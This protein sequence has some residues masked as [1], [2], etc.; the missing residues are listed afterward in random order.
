MDILTLNNM[1][2]WYIDIQKAFKS[3]EHNFCHAFSIVSALLELEE[4][5]KFDYFILKLN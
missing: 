4:H 1:G 3:K 5:E 2:I